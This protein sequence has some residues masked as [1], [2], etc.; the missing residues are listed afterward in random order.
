MLVVLLIILCKL[1]KTVQN[2]EFVIWAVKAHSVFTAHCCMIAKLTA[3]VKGGCLQ[4]PFI[5]PLTGTGISATAAVCPQNK[6]QAENG[7]L[8]SPCSVPSICV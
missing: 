8:P 7:F 4:Q 1:K 3:Y 2:S 6:S 5:L